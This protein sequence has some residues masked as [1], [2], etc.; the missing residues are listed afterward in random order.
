MKQS[1][2]LLLFLAN[3]Y[4]AETTFEDRATGIKIVIPYDASQKSAGGVND[5]NL[6]SVA[7]G[8][9]KNTTVIMLHKKNHT[10]TNLDDYIGALKEGMGKSYEIG[11]IAKAVPEKLGAGFT[12]TKAN[13]AVLVYVKKHNDSLAMITILINDPNLLQ[14]MIEWMHEH[15][16]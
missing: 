15:N 10:N 7:F 12:L 5:D 16:G 8:S 14:A 11:A 13:S 4:S 3:I 2:L 6:L 1:I 9:L